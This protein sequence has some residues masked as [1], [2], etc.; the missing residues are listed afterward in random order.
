VRVAELGNWLRVLFKFDAKLSKVESNCALSEL[1]RRVFD[2][3]PAI[4][5]IIPVFK[6]RQF[7]VSR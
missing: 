1:G 6:A 5:G 2:G 7:W 3:Y 4:F